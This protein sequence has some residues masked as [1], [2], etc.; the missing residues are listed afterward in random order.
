MN[1]FELFELP[2]SLKVET[3]TL[4]RK[5][6]E[7]S[8]KYHP[9]YFTNASPED[10][11]R[12]LELSAQLNQAFRVFQNPDETIRYVLQLKGLLEEEEKFEL[13]P[14]FLM[15]V[16]EIN[17]AMMDTADPAANEKITGAINHLQTEI[18]EPVKN[19]IENYQEGVSPEEELLQVKEYYFKK[20]YI[21][22]MKE[23]L[24]Q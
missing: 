21:D 16:L 5:Y 8:R 10:Q 12:A 20:K 22:R 2:V 11:A 24:R 1:Y 3:A 17:E 23:E 15:E 14:A 6:F 7:L 9:D 19:I 13:P 4:P 18:Y